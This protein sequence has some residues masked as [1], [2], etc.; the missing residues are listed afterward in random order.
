MLNIVKKSEFED[1]YMQLAINEAQ[2]AFDEQEVPVGCVIVQK[3]TGRLIA[4][5]RNQMEK[6][7]NPN[8]HAEMLAINE[9]C[10]KIGSKNLSGYDIYVTV[11]PCTMCASAISNTRFGR[12]Y[13]GASDEKHGAVE[14]NVRFFASGACFHRPEVYHGIK[15]RESI[16]LMQDFFKGLRNNDSSTKR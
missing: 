1:K 5:G 11:E 12:L 15:S 2:K 3:D 4:A 14:H 10:M 16:K 9:A 7:R 8:A 6:Y 13:Y